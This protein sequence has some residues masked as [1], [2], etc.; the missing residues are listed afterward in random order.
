MAAATSLLQSSGAAPNVSDF[1]RKILPY[2]EGMPFQ[3]K[4]LARRAFSSYGL[5]SFDDAALQRMDWDMPDR[6]IIEE[7]RIAADL[8]RTKLIEAGWEKGSAEDLLIRFAQN[9]GS[10][11]ADT[12]KLIGDFMDTAALKGFSPKQITDMLEQY[13]TRQKDFP[14]GMLEHLIGLMNELGRHGASAEQIHQFF[15]LLFSAAA[16][17]SIEMNVS[18][19]VHLIKNYPNATAEEIFAGIE[20]LFKKWKWYTYEILYRPTKKTIGP[21]ADFVS[22]MTKAEAEMV[23]QMHT[24]PEQVE[25]RGGSSSDHIN[26]R[27]S[28]SISFFAEHGFQRPTYAVAAIVRSVLTTTKKWHGKPTWKTFE[29]LLAYAENIMRFASGE[30]RKEDVVEPKVGKDYIKEINERML[31]LLNQERR[32]KNDSFFM[33]GSERN[34]SLK[35]I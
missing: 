27:L 33:A 12:F 13:S 2:F 7:N 17:E 6:K 15:D 29:E 24:T 32:Y 9:S 31:S 35:I 21:N 3:V 28:Q 1:D 16:S 30:I 20:P 11:S 23:A 8:V 10:A 25:S 19:L 14:S 22:D 26:D 4:K 5:A 18:T 34:S